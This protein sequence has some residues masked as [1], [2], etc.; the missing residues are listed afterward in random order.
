VDETPTVTKNHDTNNHD[1]VSFM[2]PEGGGVFAIQVRDSDVSRLDPNHQRPTDKY[3]TDTAIDF[4]AKHI[5]TTT[6]NISQGYKPF[7]CSSLFDMHLFSLVS[8]CSSG[9]EQVSTTWYEDFIHEHHMVLIPNTGNNHFSCTTLWNPWTKP[10]IFHY[11]PIF[12]YHEKDRI[13]RTYEAYLSSARHKPFLSEEIIPEPQFVQL[14]GPQQLNGF[15]CGL[16]VLSFIK[17]SLSMDVSLQS[18]NPYEHF[19]ERAWFHDDIAVMRTFYHEYMVDLSQRYAATRHLNDDSKLD[20]VSPDKDEGDGEKMKTNYSRHVST[21]RDLDSDSVYNQDI[22][23]EEFLIRKFGSLQSYLTKLP[24]EKDQQ[25]LRQAFDHKLDLCTFWKSKKTG[26][27]CGFIGENKEDLR[28]YKKFVFQPSLLWAPA[29]SHAYDECPYDAN[30]YPSLYGYQSFAV[31]ETS[32]KHY[33]SGYPLYSEEHGHRYLL[34]VCNMTLCWNPRREYIL[35]DTDS[36]TF[37][38]VQGKIS[39]IIIIIIIIIE[40]CI[41][42]TL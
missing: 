16:Y 25:C 41:I 10:L 26:I 18:D 4:I 34:W 15:D 17:Y 37:T 1:P 42:L 27:N 7:V 31:L 20:I 28:I 5:V 39:H 40:V 6:A 9:S 24:A 32:G 30:R 19:T 23:F 3:L 29:N 22:L 11:D 38:V 35:Y 8:T 14:R 12:G 2:Y 21:D 13:R 33:I 36:G